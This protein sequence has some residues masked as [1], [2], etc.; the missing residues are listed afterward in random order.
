MAAGPAFRRR[1]AREVERRRRHREGAQRRLEIGTEEVA[2]RRLPMLRGE[3][4][5]AIGS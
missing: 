2:P 5:E 3:L 4:E 1:S